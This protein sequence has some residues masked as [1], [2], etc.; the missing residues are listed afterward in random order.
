MTVYICAAVFSVATQT[1]L[2]LG[3]SLFLLER[4][5]LI[6]ILDTFIRKLPFL[7]LNSEVDIYVQYACAYKT[8]CGHFYIFLW[9]FRSIQVDVPWFEQLFQV[10]PI[11]ILIFLIEIFLSCCL[12]DISV[13]S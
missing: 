9:P 5:S 11:S 3:K 7:F 13:P 1:S 4:I 6:N 10:I 2:F 12:F 8:L